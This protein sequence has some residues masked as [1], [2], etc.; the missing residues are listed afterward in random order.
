MNEADA[1]N[2]DFLEA[3]LD[4]LGWSGTDLVGSAAAHAAWLIAQHAP[5][6]FRTRCV[7]LLAAAV[8][9]GAMPGPVCVA[10]ASHMALTGPLGARCRRTRWRP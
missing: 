9:A 2:T 4:R 10:K 8:D 3:V 7:P 6:E 5:A 1:D